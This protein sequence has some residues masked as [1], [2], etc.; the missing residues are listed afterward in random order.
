MAYEVDYER[1]YPCPC[2]CS[3]Y[4]VVSESNDWGGS[5]ER[6]PMDCLNCRER[7]VRESDTRREGDRQYEEFR[8]VP[9]LADQ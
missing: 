9:R 3:I 4:T 8:W 1:K 7:Y 6:W 2:G 5:R